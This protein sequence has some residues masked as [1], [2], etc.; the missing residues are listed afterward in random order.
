MGC[1]ISIWFSGARNGDIDPRAD[2][3]SDLSRKR[4]PPILNFD[5]KHFP[6]NQSAP[7]HTIAG[8]RGVYQTSC[9]LKNDMFTLTPCISLS[10]ARVPQIRIIHEIYG[11]EMCKHHHRQG[12]QISERN[13]S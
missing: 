11:I 10:W 7:Q 13:D 6:V 12:K 1:N 4:R 2:V 3:V 8:I 5:E 9:T